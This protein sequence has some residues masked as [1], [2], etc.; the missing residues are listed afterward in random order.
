MLCKMKD[1]Q[2]EK[3]ESM[4]FCITNKQLT[5]LT[6]ECATLDCVHLDVL[7]KLATMMKNPEKDIPSYSP[8]L[9]SY[10]D[11]T[12]SIK[13]GKDTISASDVQ[14]KKHLDETLT[15][16]LD[17]LDVL[18]KLAVI[19]KDPEN[20]LP[21]NFPLSFLCGDLTLS[22]ARKKA[23]L[24]TAELDRMLLDAFVSNKGWSKTINIL[25]DNNIL[26]SNI[27]YNSWNG[28]YTI[29]P[30]KIA[31]YLQNIIMAY[32]DLPTNYVTHSRLDI[33]V[34]DINTMERMILE[35]FTPGSLLFDAAMEKQMVDI[36]GE[37]HAVDASNRFRDIIAHWFVFHV[38]GPAATY[39]LNKEGKKTG[40]DV[41]KQPR[42][43]H[44]FLKSR[45]DRKS[46][47]MTFKH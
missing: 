17:H 13:R 46:L 37:K 26:D 27:T 10:D 22:I 23:S 1:L 15:L 35:V 9:F 28:F 36:F 42:D 41:I 4:T 21:K 3:E 43:F 16:S 7:T 19:M 6:K 34:A 2:K 14:R 45:T 31:M 33:S 32:F 40:L 39:Q 30:Y 18:T 24:P 29:T 47:E 5:Y 25:C 20:R 38:T 8:Y 44:R 12:L 11:I